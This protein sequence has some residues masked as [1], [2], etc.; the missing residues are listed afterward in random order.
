MRCLGKVTDLWPNE[1]PDVHSAGAKRA[2]LH[3]AGSWCNDIRNLE[4]SV[5]A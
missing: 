4:I 2:I 5:L 1:K 3:P